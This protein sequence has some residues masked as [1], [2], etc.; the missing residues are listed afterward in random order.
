MGFAHHKRQRPPSG[1]TR[2]SVIEHSADALPR[3]PAVSHSQ[4][5]AGNCKTKGL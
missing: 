2:R 3:P 1:T 4:K 5:Y